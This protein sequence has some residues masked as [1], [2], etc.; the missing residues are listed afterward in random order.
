MS[1]KSAE[2]HSVLH[3]WCVQADWGA[4]TI[5]GDVGGGHTLFAVLDCLIA[6]SDWS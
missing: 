2:G 1:A 3:S 5:A 4:P 6:E